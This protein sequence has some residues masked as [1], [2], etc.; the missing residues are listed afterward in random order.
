MNCSKITMRIADKI[1]MLRFFLGASLAIVLN[2]VIATFFAMLFVACAERA[3]EPIN[4]AEGGSSEEPCVQQASLEN[5]TITGSVMRIAKA[6]EDSAVSEWNIA[7]LNGSFIRMAELDSVTLDTTGVFYFAQCTGSSGKFVFE[8]VSLRSPYVMFEIAPYV[9]YGSVDKINTPFK[10]YDP[11]NPYITTTYSIIV[12]VRKAEGLDI[13][14]ITF[15]EAARLRYLVNQGMKFAEAKRQ[16]DQELLV[17]LGIYEDSVYFDKSEY[18]NYANTL[19]MIDFLGIAM[20]DWIRSSS[21]LNVANAF[22]RTG[23][24]AAVD[25]VKDYFIAQTL[26]WYNLRRFKDSEKIFLE[27]FFASLYGLG[28]CIAEREGVGASYEGGSFDDP[29]NSEQTMDITCNSGRWMFTSHYLAV[30]SI[31]AVPDKMTDERDGKVYNTVTFV[32]DGQSQTWMAENLRFSNDSIRPELSF[33]SEYV[34]SNQT[35]SREYD[36]YV[37]GLDSSYW[38]TVAIYKVEDVIG[39]DSI[40]MDEGHFQGICPSGWHIPTRKEW[41]QL[42]HFVEQKF[43]RCFN[44]NCDEPL[45]YDYLTSYGIEYLHLVGFGDFT[46]E[47]FAFLEPS[48]D[49]WTLSMLRLDKWSSFDWAYYLECSV[50][51]VKN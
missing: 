12:D 44:G 25:S 39:A 26:M 10:G 16:A 43:G 11:K 32:I 22:G 27:N 45:K 46:A 49:A 42:L 13:N 8:G 3:D 36:E 40:V 50:R 21:P 31:G 14:V 19:T 47:A 38:N 41:S 37:A 51:C 29:F 5:I 17:A 1:M 15:L 28:Q 18:M 34:A 4:G 24:L 2:L 30:D 20:Y 23:S 35:P 7:A 48:E 9:G 6:P 33:D